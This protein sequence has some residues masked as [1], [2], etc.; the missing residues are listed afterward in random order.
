MLIKFL[1][2]Y[3]LIML[4]C[5][6]FIHCVQHH[7]MPISA[8]SQVTPSTNG[9][10]IKTTMNDKSTESYDDDIEDGE[11][12]DEDKTDYAPSSL[13]V[14]NAYDKQFKAFARKG[15]ESEDDKTDY[16]PSSLEVR[17]AYDNQF[18]AFASNF[19][20]KNENKKNHVT[21]VKPRGEASGASACSSN[22]CQARQDIEQASTESI[23]KHIL[24]KL[25]MKH[26]P[27]IT[28]Y[29]K[30]TAEYREILCKRIN[31]DPEK[32]LGKKSSSLEYQSDDP[33]EFYSDYER[34]RDAIADEEDVQFL[35]F[36]NRIYAFPSS[37]LYGGM[38]L[39]LRQKLSLFR[40]EP[41]FIYTHSTAPIKCLFAVQSAT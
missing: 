36:E 15:E 14:R 41:T 16:A 3:T 31:I 12:S 13:D 4:I 7:E 40:S 39:F 24:M 34:D 10:D 19:Q 27:N 33:T 30:L 29:P 18:K 38:K 23:R 25:G 1:L 35:S 22:V 32:C 28:N 21:T 6:P 26:E 20:L 11:E 8:L 17:N 5:N 9:I 37:K 2:I